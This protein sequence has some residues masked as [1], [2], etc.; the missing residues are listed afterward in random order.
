MNSILKS[1]ILIA[2]LLISNTSYALDYIYDDLNR[3]VQVIYPTGEIINYR[4]DDVGN[5]LT[6]TQTTSQISTQ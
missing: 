1:L 3:L 4:Y 5:L 6:I 2:G